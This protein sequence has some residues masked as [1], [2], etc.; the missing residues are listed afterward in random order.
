MAGAPN[1]LC[2]EAPPNEATP[3]NDGPEEA[4]VGP[5]KEGTEPAG[6]AESV[7]APKRDELDWPKPAEL[8]PAPENDISPGRGRYRR[9]SPWLRGERGA[10]VRRSGV[11]VWCRT[12]VGVTLYR[13]VDQKMAGLQRLSLQN[14]YATAA[15]P[16]YACS[17]N[18]NERHQ[19]F[20]R[21]KV[22]S[23]SDSSQGVWYLGNDKLKYV[24][25]SSI[26]RLNL[27]FLRTTGL[28]R[29]FKNLLAIQPPH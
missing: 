17:E 27:V 1:R 3:N 26:K 16:F 23:R 21:L 19:L 18:G 20:T 8:V 29:A 13:S 15:R 11:G 25:G 6:T 4:K 28:N 9:R 22:M 10:V 2:D 5:P 7:G 24:N 14:I 12:I